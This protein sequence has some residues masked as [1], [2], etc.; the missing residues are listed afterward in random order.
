MVG[1]F[2]RPRPREAPAGYAADAWPLYLV[3]YAF[4][5]NRRF[6][7]WFMLGLIMEIAIFK[8]FG[9]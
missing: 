9:V 6:G 2:S 8:V 5:F 3:S 4:L 7:T 1:I